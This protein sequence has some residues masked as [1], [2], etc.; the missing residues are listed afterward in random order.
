MSSDP[1]A[2]ML[3]SLLAVT[4]RLFYSKGS[5]AWY[6]DKKAIIH[7]LTTPAEYLKTRGKRMPPEDYAKFMYARLEQIHAHG[8]K[9]RKHPYFPNYLLKCIQDHLAWHGDD[10][11]EDASAFGN[12]MTDLAAKLQGTLRESEIKR[13]EAEE[14]TIAILAQAH[15]LTKPKR[16]ITPKAEAPAVK[17]LGLFSLLLLIGFLCQ[18][19]SA[20]N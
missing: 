13:A 2:A 19:L 14:R 9:W 3:D 15:E 17:Q 1:T 16:K 18:K 4:F 11:I 5:T 6:R 10:L 7:A 12:V 8:E 20:G